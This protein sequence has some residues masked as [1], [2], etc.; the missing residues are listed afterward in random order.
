M[1]FQMFLYSL[2]I[3]NSITFASGLHHFVQEEKKR[4]QY[5]NLQYYRR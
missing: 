1:Y 2:L 5:R 3:F 4:N